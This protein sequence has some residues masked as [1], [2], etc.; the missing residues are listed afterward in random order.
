[1]EC[2][3]LAGGLGTRLRSLVSNLPKCMAP[4]AGKPFLYYLLHYLQNNGC[5]HVI[6]SLGYMHEEIEKWVK[7]TPWRFR[8]SFVVED[9]PL[10]TGGAIKLAVSV[11]EENHLFIINGDTYFNVDLQAM[12]HTHTKSVADLTI[13]LRHMTEFD[14]Y[15]TV[16]INSDNRILAFKEKEYCKEGF[17]NG[18]IYL[19]NKKSSLLDLQNKKFSF[20]T[21]IMQP[22]VEKNFFSGYVSNGYF[23]DI[24][25]PVDFKK[26]NVELKDIF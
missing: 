15:G 21:D 24:G 10:G 17:I 19:L 6:L 3:V 12:Y 5:D 2:I 4:I 26:A 7:E 16:K 9:E 20:E 23:I 8:I 14:R 13:A 11:T 22:S 1:M 25:I 18:G